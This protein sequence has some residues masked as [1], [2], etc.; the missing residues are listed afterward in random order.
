M[1]DKQKTEGGNERLKS[2]NPLTMAM[3][4]YVV[5]IGGI[6]SASMRSLSESAVATNESLVRLCSIGGAIGFTLGSAL[7][8]FI[9]RKSSAL[10]AGGVI[11][12][13]V[14]TVAGGLALIE[15]KNFLEISLLAFGGCWLL[16]VVMLL[17]ARFNT[18]SSLERL[19]SQSTAN[20]SPL[21]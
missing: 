21:N 6:V 3:M 11:G 12:T 8:F 2:R 10:M 18:G 9:F 7:G 13:L 17:S 16:V 14:G 15:T 1:A 20:K 19:T 5:T 4:F